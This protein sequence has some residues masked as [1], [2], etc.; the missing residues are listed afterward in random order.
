MYLL[1]SL[2][3]LWADEVHFGTSHLWSP[4]GY[5]QTAA[6]A[7]VIWRLNW[8]GCPGWPTLVLAVIPTIGW[9]QLGLLSRAPTLTSLCTLDFANL[10]SLI[11]RGRLP[12]A[13]ILRVPGRSCKT[14]YDLTLNV[15]SA[16]FWWSFKQAT[17]IPTQIQEDRNWSLPLSENNSRVSLNYHWRVE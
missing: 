14:S 2:M 8:G 13:G 12:K 15:T 9:E 6:G 7:G 17:Y 1:L 3:V 4:C 10:S 5:R 16:A 11:L